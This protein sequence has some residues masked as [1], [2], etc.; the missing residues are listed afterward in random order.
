MFNYEMDCGGNLIH[1]DGTDLLKIGKENIANDLLFGLPLED[2]IIGSLQGYFKTEI[3]KTGQYCV[4][5]AHDKHDTMIKYEIKSRR[6]KHDQYPTT[7]IP[8]HKTTVQHKTLKFVFHFTTGLYYITYDKELFDTF[9][10]KSVGAYRKQ[11]QYTYEPHYEIPIGLL[12]PI[13]I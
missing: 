3:E 7:I 12:T 5:D 8:V 6:C 11:G 4:Y 1:L 2:P 9:N 13:I 10:V